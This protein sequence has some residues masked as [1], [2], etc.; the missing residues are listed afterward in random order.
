MTDLLIFPFGGNAREAV[1][2]IDAI[3]KNGKQWN[4]L[5]FI[6]DNRDLWDQEFNG[7]KVLGGKEVLASYPQ[8]KVL[9]VPGNPDT[10]PER[11]KAIMSL[12][13][14]ESRYT[15]L[16]H[17]SARIGTG[18]TI[19]S[20]TLIMAGAVFTSD[21]RIGDH[22]VVLPNSVISHESTIEDYCII[23]SNVS[24]SGR[25]CIG[26]KS[27][28]GSGS[29]IMQDITIGGGTMIGLGSVIIRSVDPGSVVAGNP[30]RSLRSSSSKVEISAIIPAFE[31]SDG[32][33]RVI[34]TIKAYLDRIGYQDNYEIIVVDDH[35][36]DNT[37][38]TISSFKDDNVK[39]IRLSKRSGS[40][41]AI[42][43]GLSFSSG[44]AA[45][46]VS[47][48]GQEDLSCLEEMLEKWKSG[49]EVVWALRKNRDDEPWHVKLPALIF[50]KILFLFVKNSDSIDLSKADFFL[51]GEKAIKAINTCSEK[52]TSLW[53]LISWVG[54]KQDTVEYSRQK[55]VSGKTK[56][57]C[58]SRLALAANWITAFSKTPLTFSLAT[59]TVFLV[60]GLFLGCWSMILKYTMGNDLNPWA[61]FTS[62]ILVVSGVQ[63]I[64]LGIAGEHLWRDLEEKRER[65]LFLVEKRHNIGI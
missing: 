61:L 33:L 42:R 1:A 54:F 19:G 34:S 39:C 48:D 18:V 24:V 13:I 27:Y 26:K 60:T 50:Y 52:H 22:C 8:A 15:T 65:P 5:G 9:A 41:T 63:S 31:E 23:G 35:S 4:L 20:N 28:I 2:V 36:G 29:R 47:A 3:N 14:G 58:R 59:G 56:W 25:A 21:V 12:G 62:I 32:I 7:V 10:F 30:G 11:D 51:I 37:F 17:P 57:N 49:A 55:R 16:I 40:H 38:G 45:F 44:K 46:Y 6:D 43:A 53:G 64:F